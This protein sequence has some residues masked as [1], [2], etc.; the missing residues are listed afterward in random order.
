MG[1]SKRQKLKKALSPD[2]APPAPVMDTAL[3]ND[4]LMDDLLAQLD[5]KDKTVREESASIIQDVQLNQAAENTTKLDTKSRFKARIVCS[6]LSN[7][8]SSS[9]TIAPRPERRLRL[10][11]ISRQ[12]TQPLMS[13][14]ER[15]HKTKRTISGEFARIYMCAFMKY[16]LVA[17]CIL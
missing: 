14:C 15:R 11:R 13:D 2:Q 3:P 10:P 16:A 17:N 9:L 5:S 4:D 7:L 12:M 6:N 1:G 8:L